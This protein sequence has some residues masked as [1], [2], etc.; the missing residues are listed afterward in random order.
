MIIWKLCIKSEGESDER[1][2]CTYC[3]VYKDNIFIRTNVMPFDEP[4]MKGGVAAKAVYW[5]ELTIFKPLQN[6]TYCINEQLKLKVE[7]R[8]PGFNHVNY[9]SVKVEIIKSKTTSSITNRFLTWTFSCGTNFISQIF[10][11]ISMI[12]ACKSLIWNRLFHVKQNE[13]PKIKVTCCRC[14]DMDLI[15]YLNDQLKVVKYTYHID[16]KN[17]SKVR[18]HEIDEAI[19]ECNINEIQEWQNCYDQ[20]L[21]S[22]A[23]K[24]CPWLD[25]FIPSLNHRIEQAII[26]ER[27]GKPDPCTLDPSTKTRRLD[28]KQRLQ[29]DIEVIEED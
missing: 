22:E 12:D 15:N 20:Q 10:I 1:Q 28:L 26:N 24:F 21:K 17:K 14:I 23:Y 7:Y 5:Q 18:C 4:L 13:I 25:G 29:S 2:Y 11:D 27:N 6:E 16:G 8:K 9:S 3:R 19:S